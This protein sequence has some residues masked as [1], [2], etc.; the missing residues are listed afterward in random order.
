VTQRGEF[1]KLS[2]AA[3][4][5]VMENLRLYQ[6]S[7]LSKHWDSCTGHLEEAA[8]KLLQPA[9]PRPGIWRKDA[10][11]IAR[12]GRSLKRLH[13]PDLLGVDCM[14]FKDK[15]ELKSLPAP[16]LSALNAGL[17]KPQRGSTRLRAKENWG[18]AI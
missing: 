5:D 12:P 15:K 16:T 4:M 2:N 13:R 10:F 17:M 6:D 9:P 11:L 14:G 3:G 18:W 8:L 7:G 1:S